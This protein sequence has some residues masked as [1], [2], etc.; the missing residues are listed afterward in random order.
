[1]NDDL[2]AGWREV[3]PSLL[4]DALVYAEWND[5]A[6][7]ADFTVSLSKGRTVDE[8]RAENGSHRVVTVEDAVGLM[9]ADGTLSLQPLCGGLDPEVAWTYLRRVADEVVPA[10]A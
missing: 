2:D 6:G 1:V 7:M 3:G 5:A 10:L 8:L 4:A 9:K